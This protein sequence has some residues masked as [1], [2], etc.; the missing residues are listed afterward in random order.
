MKP[1]HNQKYASWNSENILFMP[2]YTVVH[3][4]PSYPFAVPEKSRILLHFENQHSKAKSI[5]SK[6]A[7]VYYSLRKC[8][9]TEKLT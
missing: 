7:T 2:G 5:S 3:N 1:E 8:P 4:Q 9:S 6:V